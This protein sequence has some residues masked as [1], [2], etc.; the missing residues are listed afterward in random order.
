MPLYEQYLEINLASDLK[1]ELKLS[2]TSKLNSTQLQKIQA[3][4]Q[5]LYDRICEISATEFLRII[6]NLLFCRFKWLD[7]IDITVKP[8]LLECN[9]N[10]ICQRSIIEYETQ[11]FGT[12][13]ILFENEKFGIYLLNIKAG[14]SIPAH[15]HLQMEEHELVLDEGL[16]FNGEN[17][18]PGSSF[19]WPKGVVHGYNNLSALP[20]TVLCIDCPKFIPEDEI[21]VNH[22][23]PLESVTPA[24]I[25]YYQGISAT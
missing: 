10:I 23:N 14:E 5:F 4:V 17:I 21:I 20:A 22:T 8:L 19:D 3:Q 7:S 13:D 1:I 25:N 12:V 24:N 15:M 16:M 2:L 6:P 11:P 9:H 18:E